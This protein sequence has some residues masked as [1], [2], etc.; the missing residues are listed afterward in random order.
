M[1]KEGNRP[2]RYRYL[3]NASE[4]SE[5]REPR[6]EGRRSDAFVFTWRRA[7]GFELLRR[8]AVW[9]TKLFSPSPFLCPLV[10]ERELRIIPTLSCGRFKWSLLEQHPR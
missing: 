2:N 9:P 7:V 3:R 6:S 1:M 4:E 10:A 5:G 8:G